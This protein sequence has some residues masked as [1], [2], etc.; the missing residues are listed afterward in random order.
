MAVDD[1]N[2]LSLDQ[3]V[4]QVQAN[5]NEG[6][7]S[8]RGEGWFVA[9]GFL[10]LGILFAPPEPVAPA[11]ELVVGLTAIATVC[12]ARAVCVCVSWLGRPASPPGATVTPLASLRDH[13][14]LP[15]TVCRACAHVPHRVPWACAGSGAGSGR[16]ERSWT[17]QPEP[18]AKAGRE[19]RAEDRRFTHM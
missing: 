10:V 13:H 12:R 5:V 15:C 19:Q 17:E 16:S 14:P 2:E 7:L 9:Q 6:E 3:M 18:V 4:A 1:S 11:A 8:T